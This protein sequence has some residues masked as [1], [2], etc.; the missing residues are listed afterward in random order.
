[1]RDEIDNAAAFDMLLVNSRY[2]AESVL[3]AYGLT[4]RVCYL[5]VRP[6]LWEIE[7]H[8]SNRT[9]VGIGTL[10]PHKR[11]HF[12]LSALAETARPLPSLQW[13][14][15]SWSEEYLQEVTR[16]AEDLG[17]DF[18]AHLAVSH[19]EMLTILAGASLLAYAPRL[20]P[21]G[22]APLE[23]AAAGLPTV[24]VAEGGIRETV[25]HGV[26]GLLVQDDFHEMAE[27]IN[28]L[29]K[30]SVLRK[31]L[32]TL[33]RQGVLQNWTFEGAID[34]LESELERLEHPSK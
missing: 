33:A 3:R 7:C 27:A 6:E 5:G 15:N 20:E 17:I 32:G 21:F 19:E 16:Q 26:T 11:V 22:Y 29:L 1:V 18:K 4:S 24:A 23:C 12:V 8:T 34:R 2:S 28:Q 31:Q 9:V 13:I 30:D 10:A 14:G 25:M